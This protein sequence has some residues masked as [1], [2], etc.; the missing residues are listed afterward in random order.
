MEDAGTD[1]TQPTNAITY[2]ASRWERLIPLT[3]PMFAIAVLGIFFLPAHPN[4]EIYLH[5]WMLLTLALFLFLRFR[6]IKA[7][8]PGGGWVRKTRALTGYQVESYQPDGSPVLKKGA[9]VSELLLGIASTMA[10]FAEVQ[11]LIGSINPYFI[12]SSST[13]VNFQIAAITLTMALL[14][15]TMFSVMLLVRG[16]RPERI[17][18]GRPAF[19]GTLGIFAVLLAGVGFLVF[20]VPKYIFVGPSAPWPTL[21]AF[22]QGQA[23][24]IDKDAVLQSVSARPP[25]DLSAPYSPRNTPF[26]LDFNYYGISGKDIT[27]VVLDVDPPRLL[28]IRSESF[29]SRAEGISDVLRES[30]ERAATVKLPPREVYALTEAE[31]LEFGKE[32]NATVSPRLSLYVRDDMQDSV[33]VPAEWTITYIADQS[34]DYPWLILRVD[35]ATGKVVGRRYEP[36]DFKKRA[37]PVPVATPTAI[38]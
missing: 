17:I 22:A 14:F 34:P 26:E 15:I 3:V 33:V 9:F 16:R 19:Y 38:P 25:Y 8:N 28:S 29:Y 11:L 30:R 7:R 20:Q 27:I 6:L 32:G 23:E 24:R 1:P 37:T 4:I 13:S 12:A 21:F 36:E 18:G 5:I 31:G 10:A 35:G 2:P